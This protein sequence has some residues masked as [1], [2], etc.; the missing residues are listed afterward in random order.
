MFKYAD[1]ACNQL[2]SVSDLTVVPVA[3]LNIDS[4][5]FTQDQLLEAKGGQISFIYEA[6]AGCFNLKVIE[7][8]SQVVC[9]ES[10]ERSSSK[11]NLWRVTM[12]V[13]TEEVAKIILSF[14][15]GDNGQLIERQMVSVKR[16]A[17]YTNAD[18]HVEL[19]VGT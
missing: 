18:F 1:A 4:D 3:P 7:S 17:G 16:V 13:T 8:D 15:N 14:A 2:V 10:C 5:C 19:E 12:E 11:R 9:V 6:P